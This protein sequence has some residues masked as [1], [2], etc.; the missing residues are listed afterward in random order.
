MTHPAYIDVPYQRWEWLIDTYCQLTGDTSI[1]YRAHVYY[2]AMLVWWNVRWQRYRYEVPR[3][4]DQRLVKS[5]ATWDEKTQQKYEHYQN[6]AD[7]FV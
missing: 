6:L 3:G 2:Q 1:A 5:P 4:L 7:H